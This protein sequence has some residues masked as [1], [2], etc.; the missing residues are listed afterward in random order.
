[1]NLSVE[2]R[3]LVVLFLCFS[4]LLAAGSCSSHSRTHYISSS[5]DDMNTGRRPGRPWKSIERVNRQEFGQGDRILFRGG[6]RF[7]G[8]IE[9]ISFAGSGRKSGNRSDGI[10]VT[11]CNGILASSV[12]Y[13]TI[14]YCEAFNNGWDMPWTGNGPVGIWIWDCT[15]FTIQHCISHHN[16]NH[17]E[18]ADG[19]G[20]DFDGGV[21]N[22]T[23]QY[24]IS[25]HNEGAGYGLYELLPSPGRIIRSGTT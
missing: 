7:N 25:H 10:L 8:T 3:N 13:G 18:A 6:E 2:T 23:I 22:S 4:V 9:R 5:G 11:R 21:S 12:E 16:R 15:D 24:C 14:E 20:F 1:M 17:P 19:G